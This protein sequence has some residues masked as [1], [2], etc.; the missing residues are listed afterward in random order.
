M[1]QVSFKYKIQTVSYNYSARS[2]QTWNQTWKLILEIL[3]LKHPSWL[4]LSWLVMI[5]SFCASL[6]DSLPEFYQ[7]SRYS[8]GLRTGQP[9]FDSRHDKIFLFSTAFRETLGP[10]Q[11]PNQWVPGEISQEVM[12]PGRESDRSP[13]SSA[14]VKNGGTVLPLPVCLHGILLN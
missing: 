7:L 5:P 6:R 11:P 10:T 1:L 13:P 12:R 4:L 9:E 8:D 2:L 14:E 3:K